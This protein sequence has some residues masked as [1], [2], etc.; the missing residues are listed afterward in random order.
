MIRSFNGK[1]PLI[2]PT[3]FVSEAA[4]LVGDVEVGEHSSI[5]PGV[6][7]RADNGKITI[8]ANTNVQ[9]NAVV[10]ADHSAAIGDHVT[11]GHGVV[12]HAARVGDH[13]LLGNGC[14]VNE[15]ATIGRYALVAANSV[16]LEGADVAD[17]TVVAGAPA[18]VR[19]Q[20]AKRHRDM[21]DDTW[22]HYVAKTAEFKREGGLE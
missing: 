19:G 7:I 2:H 9:D 17:E 22:R 20:I 1:S 16:V 21:M 4:Y 13:A 12:C 6:V 11:L 5:W 10:H 3:A 15:G 8:G 14:V 18:R